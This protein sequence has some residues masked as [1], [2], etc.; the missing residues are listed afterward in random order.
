MQNN[1]IAL[2][3]QVI[4]LI[5]RVAGPSSIQSYERFLE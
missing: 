2:V 3:V 5:K 1:Q 4:A